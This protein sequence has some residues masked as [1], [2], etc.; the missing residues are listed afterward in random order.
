MLDYF[1]AEHLLQRQ[2]CRAVFPPL[3]STGRRFHLGIWNLTAVSCKLKAPVRSNDITKAFLTK[4]MPWKSNRLMYPQGK[5]ISV[6]RSL[7][8]SSWVTTKW[9]LSTI[10]QHDCEKEEIFLDE[11]PVNSVHCDLWCMLLGL[12]KVLCLQNSHFFMFIRSHTQGYSIFSHRKWGMEGEESVLKSENTE[13]TF[14]HG[15]HVEISYTALELV[16]DSSLWSGLALDA[17]DHWE[18]I[19][20]GPFLG[21]RCQ[22]CHY[23]LPPRPLFSI[24]GVLLLLWCSG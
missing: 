8:I 4:I 3:L 24:L 14:T 11:K 19:S 20:D 5:L 7:F 22:C 13:V 23:L 15:L 12:R 18:R 21:E 17:G 10:A 1:H 9:T 2:L 6:G 16:F